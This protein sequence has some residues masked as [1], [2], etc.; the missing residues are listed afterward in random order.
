MKN[1]YKHLENL[2]KPNYFKKITGNPL[3]GYIVLIV[4]L[5]AIQLLFMYTEGIVS[6]TVSRAICMTMIYT[7]AAMGLGVLL[8]L[9]GLASLGTAAFIGVGAYVAGNIMKALPMP[10]LVVLLG[11]TLIA[12]VL[13]VLVGFISLRVRGLHLMIITL[14]LAQILNELFRTPNEFTGGPNGLTD[15]PFPKLLMLIQLNRET[16]FFIILAVMLLLII[17][18]LNL[19]NSPTGRAMMAMSSSESLAQAM[20]VRL[21][22]YRVLAFVIATVYAMIAGALYISSL[23]AATPTTWTMLM[24]L[25]ILAA[26]ILGGNAKPSSTIIGAFVIFCV[27]LAI[28][29]NIPFFI[30]YTTASVI[31]SGIL[32]VLIVV[33]YPG[34][35]ARLLQNTKNGIQKLAAKWRMYKYGPE[36]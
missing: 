24:S 2:Y 18:T 25:N 14:A 9:A 26:V 6:L 15:V 32:I 20:G 8:G 31:F 17:L 19:I 11:V 12:V 1:T 10:F 5:A 16:V 7:I 13:G 34:G 23:G 36:N 29:K 4:I 28:L 21:L 3:F 27:D 22:K 35:L 33:K 30:K